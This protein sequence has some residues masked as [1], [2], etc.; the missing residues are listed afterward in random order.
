MYPGLKAYEEGF[1]KEGV[2][3]GGL[4]LLTYVRGVAPETFLKEV[5][6][7]YEEIVKS[8]MS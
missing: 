4:T 7:D 5:E 8:K 1:V 3:A 2:G 6:R